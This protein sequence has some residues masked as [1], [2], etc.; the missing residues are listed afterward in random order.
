M[1]LNHIG[2]VVNDIE[3]SIKVYRE[4]GYIL[5]SE[6]HLDNV[7]NNKLV[8]LENIITGENIEL[9]QSINEKSTII[10]SKEG[11]HHLCYEVKNINQFIDNFNS[12]KIGII[13]TDKIKAPAF[14]NRN[15]IFAYL[16]NNTIVEFLET[17][18]DING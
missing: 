8:F 11:Y 18:D 4:L 12:K 3:K 15:V 6:I 13:F 1:K 5:K 16:K 9:I 10:N 14:D 17:E 7:Q 2:I